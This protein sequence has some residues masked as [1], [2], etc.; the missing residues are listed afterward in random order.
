MLIILLKFW[1]C[2]EKLLSWEI[3]KV[4]I[5]DLKASSLKIFLISLGPEIFVNN[6]FLKIESSRK[7]PIFS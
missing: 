5:I 7:N 4:D 1:K 3:L 6:S 2:T